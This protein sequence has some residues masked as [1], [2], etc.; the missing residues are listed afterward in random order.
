MAR[1]KVTLKK[2]ELDKL[3]MKAKRALLQEKK[4]LHDNARV[5]NLLPTS[6]EPEKVRQVIEKEKALKKLHNVVLSDC[7]MQCYPRK[8]KP[9]KKSIRRSWDKPKGRDNERSI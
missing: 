8:S 5:K 9:I 7:L 1:N 2:L 6:N 3:E 4:V